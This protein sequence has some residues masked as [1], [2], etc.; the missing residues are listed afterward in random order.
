MRNRFARFATVCRDFGLRVT[1][2]RVA[3]YREVARSKEHPDVETVF[4]RVRRQIPTLS[5]DTVYR[6]LS[7]LEEAGLVS[8]VETL[9]G[10]A[11][12]DANT[13]RHHHY[14]CTR[15]GLVRDFCSDEL[16]DFSPPREVV[17]WGTVDSVHVQLRGM[18]TRCRVAGTRRG[19]GSD[20][21]GL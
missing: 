16:A 19:S 12:F 17:P 14:V 6:T 9:S 10:P 8:R 2:Q 5:L 18:C 21:P 7:V 11:R 4:N 13:T 3:V 1:P 15:C 20:S